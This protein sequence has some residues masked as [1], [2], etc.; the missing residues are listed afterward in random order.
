[1]PSEKIAGFDLD[2][3]LVDSSEQIQNCLQRTCLELLGLDIQSDL[4]FKNLG[5]PL[6]KILSKLNLN[7]KV[8]S[9]VVTN[10]RI[11][12]QKDIL[13]GNRVFPGALNVI[14]SLVNKNYKIAVATSKPSFLAQSVVENSSL[15]GLISCV[16]GTDNFPPKPNTEVLFRLEKKLNGKLLVM[17]GDRAEDMQAAKTFGVLAIGVANSAHSMSDLISAG[18]D[19]AFDSFD[20]LHKSSIIESTL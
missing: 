17:F 16:Q 7:E 18:A 1:M 19:Y 12:L 14:E 4:V 6:E 3:T 13:K 11:N 15:S 20:Q 8:I 10:F 5:Q 9:E 2:G